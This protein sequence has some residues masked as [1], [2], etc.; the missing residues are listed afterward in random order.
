M[1]HIV[2][3]AIQSH[4]IDYCLLNPNQHGFVKGGS[5][6]TQHMNITNSWLH[7]LDFSPPP[8]IDVIFLDFA[9]AFDVIPHDL[10]LKKLFSQFFSSGNIWSWISS[11]FSCREQRVSYR[12][13]ISSWLPITSG[14]PQGSV[15][16]PCLF[17]LFIK[18]LSQT[19]S[20]CALFADDTLS[21]KP[22][23]TPSDCQILQSD[24]DSIHTHGV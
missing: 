5:C 1:E 8:K 22:I 16:G 9:K 7:L 21:Y 24:I 3:G 14:V 13:A 12:G 17:N 11:F 6:V 18:D 4:T 10:L 2:T 23:F 19:Q 15:L 20:P